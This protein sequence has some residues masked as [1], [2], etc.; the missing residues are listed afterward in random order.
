MLAVADLLDEDSLRCDS[1][2]LLRHRNGSSMNRAHWIRHGLTY[3]RVLVTNGVIRA[4]LAVPPNTT[5]AFAVVL[6]ALRNQYRL[7]GFDLTPENGTD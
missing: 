1:E 5:P 3:S 6:S 2:T 4:Q 7:V